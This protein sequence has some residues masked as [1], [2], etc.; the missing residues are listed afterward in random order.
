MKEILMSYEAEAFS[1]FIEGKS[2]D[3]NQRNA[4]VNDDLHQLVIA[5]AGSGKTRVLTNRIAYL[6]ENGVEPFN[7]LA[8]T[9]TN[10]AADN[11][12]FKLRKEFSEEKIKEK[13]KEKGFSEKEI[14]GY[15]KDMQEI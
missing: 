9:F 4:V 3:E 12:S 6:I 1:K 7:I 14:E 5:G 10:K 8:I 2:L 15:T 13:H 11:L